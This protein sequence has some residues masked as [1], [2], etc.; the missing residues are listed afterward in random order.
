MLFQWD[1]SRIRWFLA[2][3][4]YTGF[5][6]K[7]SEKIIPHIEPGS[8]LCDAGCGLGRLDLELAAYVKRL[9]A[10]DI[11]ENVI[12]ALRR[13]AEKLG[14]QNLHARAGD[15][16]S[17]T[18]TFDIVLMS[19]FGKSGVENYLKLCRRKLV[20]IVNADNKSSLYP[21]SHRSIE[22]DTVPIVQKEL[23]DLRIAYK[24]ELYSME[25]G[26]PFR[27][28][29][30]AEQFVQNNAPK[31]TE[32]E[33][34]SFLNDRITLTGRSDFPLYLPNRKELGIFI[35]DKED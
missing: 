35:I 6:K 18:E 28:R 15:A 25:F 34:S 24:L 22:K 20:R 32:A 4:D 2:A 9:T 12:D 17:M 29:R 11:N 3:S 7:L 31:A 21:E 30:D 10:V 8:T 27:S 5:H 26:Q 14:L 16:S 1:E 13:D 23:E 19:F 33:I